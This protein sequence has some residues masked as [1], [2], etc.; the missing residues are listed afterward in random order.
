MGPTRNSQDFLNFCKE[1]V[2]VL[3]DGD[4][5]IFI[6]DQLN[7]HKSSLLVKWIAEE[8]GNKGPL[9]KEREKGVLMNMKSRMAFLEDK[10]HR[11]RFI[12][13]PKH[14]SWINPIENWFGKL[15]NQVI[16]DGVFS[17]VEELE[18][19]ISDYIQYYNTCL[20]KPLKWKFKGFIKDKILAP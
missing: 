19:K 17:S 6:A 8:L 14:C 1:T 15:Q 11:I 2:A 18:T 12:Y 3:P 5:I 20:R 9:G 13:S 4:E 10:Q 16:T 7:T